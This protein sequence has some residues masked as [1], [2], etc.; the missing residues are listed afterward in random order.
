MGCTVHGR[1]WGA[2]RTMG[3]PIGIGRDHGAEEGRRGHCRFGCVVDCSRPTPRA[4]LPSPLGRQRPSRSGPRRLQSPHAESSAARSAALTAPFPSRSPAQGGA[5]VRQ[6]RRPTRSATTSVFEA[7]SDGPPEF[8]R[9]SVS[10]NR[11]KERSALKAHTRPRSAGLFAQPF[12]TN[13]V[14]LLPTAVR[15]EIAKSSGLSAPALAVTAPVFRRP[16]ARHVPCSAR[17]CMA[18]AVHEWPTRCSAREADGTAWPQCGAS[19]PIGARY[20]PVSARH[21]MARA[22]HRSPGRHS[23]SAT[24]SAWPRTP[25]FTASTSCARR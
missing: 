3:A 16:G 4:A 2:A 24:L 10:V 12:E 15:G 9:S 14:P 7:P 13:T 17:H 22:V 25:A 23:P 21:C 8:G 11:F 20:V 6:A 19:R 1:P 18:R 5:A